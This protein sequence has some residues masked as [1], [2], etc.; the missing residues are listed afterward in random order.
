MQCK[1]DIY[2]S[3]DFGWYSVHFHIFC[4]GQGGQG[5]IFAYRKKSGTRDKSNLLTVSQAFWGQNV[6]RS[7]AKN[8]TKTIVMPANSLPTQF[9]RK[10]KFLTATA[11][12]P[13]TL[14]N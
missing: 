2:F 12:P 4:S 8:S 9:S 6:G 11:Q 14:S 3:F 1:R 10:T 7:R 5:A 13:N